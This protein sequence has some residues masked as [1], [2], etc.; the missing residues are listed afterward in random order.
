MQSELGRL[1]PP[2]SPSTFQT[3]LHCFPASSIP[4]VQ[5]DKRDSRAFSF[6]VSSPV[7]H[8][9]YAIKSAEQAEQVVS[10]INEMF[11]VGLRSAHV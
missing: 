9:F 11:H 5:L 7:G 1:P 4:Y 2:Q 6:V 3:E 10:A 8:K